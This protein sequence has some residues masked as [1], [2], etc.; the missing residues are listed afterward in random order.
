MF[1]RPKN[2]FLLTFLTSYNL[3]LNEIEI[4][5]NFKVGI[6]F[7][8][9]VREIGED[10]ST[11]ISSCVFTNFLVNAGQNMFEELK[12]IYASVDSDVFIND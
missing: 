1:K 9:K 3:S 6:R 12:Q 8:L 5:Q 11:C 10:L 2:K 4:T 7:L